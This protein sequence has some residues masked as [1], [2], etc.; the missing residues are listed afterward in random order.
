MGAGQ[1]G[2][3]QWS[4]VARMPPCRFLGLHLPLTT[5]IWAG[6]VDDVTLAGGSRAWILEWA[7]D[8]I[9]VS[10]RGFGTGTEKKNPTLCGCLCA[11]GE[12]TKSTC[13]LSVAV[14][15]SKQRELPS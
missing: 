4:P 11:V 1:R 5:C 9:R 2:E 6:H 12:D 8:P 7:L 10:P 15:T 3:P 14:G 13:C